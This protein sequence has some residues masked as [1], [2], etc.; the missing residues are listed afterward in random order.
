[1]EGPRL[2]SDSIDIGIRLVSALAAGSLFLALNEASMADPRGIRTHAL[3]CLSFR[4]FDGGSGLPG[5]VA[6]HS[7]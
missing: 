7:A 5:D 2:T 1:M 6:G 4:A 3:V